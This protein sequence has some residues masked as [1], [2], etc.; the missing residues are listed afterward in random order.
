MFSHPST[1]SIGGGI[2]WIPE[3]FFP[4][5]ISHFYLQ[6]YFIVTISIGTAFLTSAA[7]NRKWDSVGFGEHKGQS[8]KYS[9]SVHSLSDMELVTKK[10]TWDQCCI[11]V[12]VHVQLNVSLCK[13]L[14]SS[15]IILMCFASFSLTVTQ[16]HMY[17]NLRVYRDE[18]ICLKLC[19]EYE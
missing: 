11:W 8:S 16:G 6:Q 13:A 12:K 1:L 7:Q 10:L 4:M 18:V 9:G 14:Y 17:I 15:Q 19:E 2:Y 5:C 3:I